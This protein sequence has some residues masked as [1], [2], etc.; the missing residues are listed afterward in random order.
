MRVLGEFVDKVGEEGCGRVSASEEDV[1]KFGADLLDVRAV[2]DEVV[3]QDV[4]VRAARSLDR[5][6]VFHSKGCVDDGVNVVVEIGAIAFVLAI[7]P[8]DA[9]YFDVT[10]FAEVFNAALED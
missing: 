2:D 7:R 6:V 4:A 10:A 5:D 3:E 1:E 8:A 9:K